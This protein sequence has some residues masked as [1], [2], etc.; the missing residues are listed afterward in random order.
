MTITLQNTEKGQCYAV[1]FDR[2]RQQVVDKLKSSVS[3]RWWDKQ[4]GAWLIP[5]TNKCKAELDQLTYYVRHFEPVQWGTV[6]QSQTEEDVAFQIPEMPEL[7]GDHGLKIQ[8]YPYQLQGIARGLQLKRFIN[9]DDMGLGKSLES[10]ATINKADAFPC[11][12]IC[13]NVVKINWQREWHKFTDKKAMVLTDSVR[14][15]WPFFWQTG[16]NQV[17]IVNYESLRKYFVRRITKA[18]KW[19]LKDVEFHNTIKLF[20]SVIIDESHKVKSTATQQTKFCKGIASGKEYIILLTGTPVV[21]KPKDL[22]AQL[23]IMD[24]MIDMGGWKGF[25]L[26]YCSGPNQ[27][28]N[29][30]ELNYK[31]W[32]HCFFRRE[33]SKVLTQLPDKVRQIVSCEITNRKEYM[34]AERDLIDYLKRYKEADDEKIQK[35]L[36]GEVMVRIGIL[37]DI[38][39]RGKLKEVI[40]FVK[41]FREN[42]KKIILF[43]NL[44]EI[45]DRLMIAFP[46]AVCVTG[47]QNMQEKQ[48]SVDAFQKNPKTDVIICSIKAASAG[49]T[50]TA[51]SDV[52]FIEL[53]W[54]Y[55]DCDQAESRAHRIGQ[56]DSVNCYYLLGRRTID[57]KLYRIIE[58]KKHISNAVLG[59]EDNIQTNIVDMVANLFDTNEEEE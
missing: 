45:V 8:P 20:K 34:D 48:A 42:G 14:D 24:R 43:C 27:A 50:L 32:Q 16:M 22:V 31:L 28:S 54:T 58:E 21:N 7:D 4:T 6:A 56:K 10:I 2:Y 36:K 3:I 37:K 1:K 33:K 57:Q 13:P 23:G 12:V 15:S 52:A 44:H 40:D 25:M 19:T 35:S 46:S 17:F 38:T 41:D 59:A 51:A 5:A 30:K 29:L 53:P 18:E 39:A 55:A 26:R 9:G 49:I 47:R 11:L